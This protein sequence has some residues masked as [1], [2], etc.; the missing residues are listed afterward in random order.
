MRVLECVV[1]LF[2]RQPFSTALG[3]EAFGGR[4]D[5][6]ERRLCWA[7]SFRMTALEP[8]RESVC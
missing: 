3:R 2:G 7:A 8:R 5:E 1:C 6:N 4:A